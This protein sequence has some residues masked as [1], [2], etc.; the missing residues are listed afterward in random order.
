M[1]AFILWNST[2]ADS[3]N[4]RFVA[5]VALRYGRELRRFL[6]IHLRDVDDVPDMAQ[7][8]YL[9]LLRVKNEEA[10]RDP[11]AYLFMVASEVLQQHS[12]PRAARSH[13]STETAPKLITSD[14][15]DSSD[16]GDDS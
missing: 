2:A 16:K 12:S 3:S 13:A 9:R 4:S 14:R 10:I 6:S 1:G 5:S 11:E 15:E 8:V 7:K